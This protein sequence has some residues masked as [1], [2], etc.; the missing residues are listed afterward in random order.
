MSRKRKNHLKAVPEVVATPE[1]SP[2]IAIKPPPGVKQNVIFSLP[3]EPGEPVYVLTGSD[4]LAAV[5]LRIW[6]GLKLK[7]DG[8][9]AAEAAAS[10]MHHA[11]LMVQ[12]ANAR[13]STEVMQAIEGHT[14]EGQG[15]P[16][17][18]LGVKPY[19]KDEP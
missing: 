13:D 4:P 5:V 1:E 8:Q 18:P 17:K 6:A 14:P 2:G 9:A 19:V 3:I 15:L 12:W 10:A 11:N 16:D 7:R